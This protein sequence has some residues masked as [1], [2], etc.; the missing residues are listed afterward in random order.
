[1]YDVWVFVNEGT[2]DIPVHIDNDGLQAIIRCSWGSQCSV[3]WGPQ[4]FSSKVRS[5]NR[6]HRYYII[7]N[8]IAKLSLEAAE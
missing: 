2:L 5:G 8:Y 1:M 4:Y 7:Y 6:S 3:H